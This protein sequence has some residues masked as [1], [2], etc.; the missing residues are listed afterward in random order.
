MKKKLLIIALC[1]C[2]LAVF[3]FALIP[4][5]AQVEATAEGGTDNRALAA[6][7]T[8]MLNRNYCYNADFESEDVLTENSLLALLDKRNAENPDYIN[9]GFVKGFV[10]DM[11]GVDIMEINDDAEMHKQGFVYIT[12]R[13]FTTY[14]HSIEKISKNEDG[15]FTVISEV[16]INPHDDDAFKTTAET[17]FVPNTSS[18]FGYNIIYSN[19]ALM[20]S[21]I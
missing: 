19:L 14:R 20:T 11:Y 15:S 1:L 2:V 7:F 9:E 16:T 21:G 17:L 18:A 12:P 3:G 13:G 4:A 8:N 5:S 6:R 10:K